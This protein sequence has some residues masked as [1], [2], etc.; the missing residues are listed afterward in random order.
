VLAG[1]IFTSIVRVLKPL[2]VCSI[3]LAELFQLMCRNNVR[4][5]DLGQSFVLSIHIYFSHAEGLKRSSCERLAARLFIFFPAY[6]QR[7]A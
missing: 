1:L 5:W 7:A 2:N 6:V 4:N 3:V